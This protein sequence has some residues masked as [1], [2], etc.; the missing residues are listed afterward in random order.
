MV[1]SATAGKG[2]SIPRS[3][4]VL[5][6]FVYQGFLSNSHG[7]WIPAQLMAIGSPPITW[8][9][10]QNLR[11]VGVLLDTALP[12]PSGITGVMLCYDVEITLVTDT[13]VS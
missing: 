9:L 4:K 1:A 10:K 3:D 7:V 8:D 6:S 12:N 2:G 13:V 5:L 11:I